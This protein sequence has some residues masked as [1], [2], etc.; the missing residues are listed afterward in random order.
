MASIEVVKCN[1]INIQSVGN[2][3]NKIKNLIVDQEIDIC[4]L[5]ETWLRNNI[6]DC[7]KIHDMT[8]DTHDFYHIP[9]E[10]KIGGGVGILANKLYKIS[11]VNNHLFDSFEHINLKLIKIKVY[12]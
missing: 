2:K 7:S 10:S 6:S 4:M 9:R 11:I 12:K 5:T 8:P 3:T 1:L